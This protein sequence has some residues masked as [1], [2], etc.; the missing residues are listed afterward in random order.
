MVLYSAVDAVHRDFA[1]EHMLFAAV[2]ADDQAAILVHVD[3]FARALTAAREVKGH[4]A[5]QIDTGR[6]VFFPEGCKAVP[7]EHIHR[8]VKAEIGQALG[9]PCGV[10]GKVHIGPLQG[11]RRAVGQPCGVEVALRLGQIDADAAQDAAPLLLVAV[12]D[13]FAQD[14]DDL[15]AVQQKVI[16]PLD[17]TIDAVAQFQLLADCKAVKTGQVWCV[18]K[19]FYQES[20]A[21]GN[22]ILDVNTAAEDNGRELYFLK[23][24]T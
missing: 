21:L 18:T 15:F 7:R 16:G 11:Q 12:G 14:A 17:L 24:L 1:G 2:G 19:N 20:L 9:Q 13:A 8:A 5:A 4:P 3:G 23:Q 10:G 6:F 22:F